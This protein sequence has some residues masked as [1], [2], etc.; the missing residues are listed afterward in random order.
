MSDWTST[1]DDKN[2]PEA[3]S[4]S[5]EQKKKS[6][7]RRHRHRGLA[8][9]CDWLRQTSHL[10]NDFPTTAIPLHYLRNDVTG[11][12]VNNERTSIHDLKERTR[13]GHDIGPARL[14]HPPNRRTHHLRR[15]Q[16]LDRW[17]E[18]IRDMKRCDKIH[19]LG[20]EDERQDR[21]HPFQRPVA[22]V[23]VTI[24]RLNRMIRRLREPGETEPADGPPS[25]DAADV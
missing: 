23:V 20:D 21:P 13:I 25:A 14:E 4:G 7:W 2:C 10:S 16:R 17:R 8:G 24:P 9:E 18:A 6:A 12:N 15:H 1:G 22:V 11:F 19:G 5:S 3:R